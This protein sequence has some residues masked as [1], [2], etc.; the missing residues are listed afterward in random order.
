MKKDEKE[1]AAPHESHQNF[2]NSPFEMSRLPV[3]VP[4]WR[5][6]VL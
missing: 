5:K 2:E 6:S 1:G 4:R 3:F